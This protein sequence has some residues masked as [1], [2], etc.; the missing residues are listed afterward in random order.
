MHASDGASNHRLVEFLGALSRCQDVARAVRSAAELGAEEFDAEIGAVVIGDVVLAG[1][2]F[3]PDAVPVDHLAAIPLGTS[4]V[5]LGRAGTF[6]TIAAAWAAGTRGR[7]VVARATGPFSLGDRNLLLGMAGALGLAL[8]MIQVLERQR[9]EQRVLEVLLDIQRRISH[10]AP[11]PSILAAVTDGARAVLPGH[12]V[13]LV[14]DD[15]LDPAHPIVVGADPVASTESVASTVPVHVHGEPVGSLVAWPQDRA[16]GAPDQ[17]LLQS[18]AEHAS[19]ALA[20]AQAVEAMEHA[21]H[22]PLTGAPN[23]QLF[24]DRLDQALRQAEPDKVPS[25]LFIDLDRFKAVNDT[26]GHAAGDT[27]LIEVTRRVR[28]VLTSAGTVAR[29]G[30][31]EFAV[32]LDGTPAHVTAVAQR[33]LRELTRPFLIDGKVAYIGA[34]I[35]VAHALTEPGV[36]ADALVGHADVAMYRA[37]AAGGGAVLVY[38]PEMRVALLGRLELQADLHGALDR[39]ELSLAYQPVVDLRTGAALGIEALLRWANPRTGPVP[40]TDFVPLAEVTGAIVP[41]GRWVLEEACRTIAGLRRTYPNLTVG[42]NVSVHQLRD[43]SFLDDVRRAL[44]SAGLPGRALLL[45]ITEGVLLDGEERMVDRLRA[46]KGLGVSVALDDFGTGYSSLG[47][48]RRFPVDVLKI[49]RSFVS[50]SASDGD[51]ELVRMIIE[52]GRAYGLAVVAEGIEDEEQRRHLAD[53]GC[54]IAQGYLFS[55]PTDVAGVEEY[56]A[57]RSVVPQQRW[58]DRPPSVAPTGATRALRPTR[59]LG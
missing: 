11:L 4:S 59:T 32:L 29:F 2:G 44:D 33:V 31:D 34:T 10:R 43:R 12:D 5:D 53:L 35:G 19:L 42:V 39:G 13:A 57:R 49:D 41:I 9:G 55:R 58:S 54:G 56:L 24:L 36:R 27:L 46:L 50:G 14:L 22:D 30:G 38:D 8:D 51:D 37:K 20:D 16:A 48:L 40:P 3:G 7:L 1:V 52:L 45:E 47:Y 18:F 6:H 23:R 26:M 15:V 17:A 21:F 25:V 28:S